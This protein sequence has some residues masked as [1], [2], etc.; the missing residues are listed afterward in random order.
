MFEWSGAHLCDRCG[1]AESSEL[2]ELVHAE[3]IVREELFI[4]A[5]G[6]L[7]AGNIQLENRVMRAG[8]TQQQPNIGKRI[9]IIVHS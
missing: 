3:A 7:L 4:D 9:C 6:F 5:L 2:H 8:S 1:T